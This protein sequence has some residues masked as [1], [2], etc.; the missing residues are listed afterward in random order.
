MEKRLRGMG[1]VVRPG[2]VTE[3]EGFSGEKGKISYSVLHELPS[4]EGEK[5]D[6]RHP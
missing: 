6:E 1:K 2:G 4:Q 3:T 5:A